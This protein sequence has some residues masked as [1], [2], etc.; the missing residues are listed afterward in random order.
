[1]STS[2][3]QHNASNLSLSVIQILDFSDMK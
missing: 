3:V 1:L 2:Q